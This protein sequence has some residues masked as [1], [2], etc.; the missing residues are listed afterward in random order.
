MTST[1]QEALSALAQGSYDSLLK[2]YGLTQDIFAGVLSKSPVTH[3]Q[4]KLIDFGRLL[5]QYTAVPEDFSRYTLKVLFGGL[6]VLVTEKNGAINIKSTVKYLQDLVKG[7]PGWCG[8]KYY[9]SVVP[10][11]PNMSYGTKTGYP[12]WMKDDPYRTALC[13]FMVQHC[14]QMELFRVAD[15]I[16]YQNIRTMYSAAGLPELAREIARRYDE[17]GERGQL[18]QFLRTLKS[19]FATSV[20][21]WPKLS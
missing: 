18:V 16:Q 6:P 9:M 2:Q 12:W 4:V 19:K 15:V 17:V 11:G 21:D 7:Q 5:G 3:D 20:A 10:H 1:I 13:A 14:S 8:P